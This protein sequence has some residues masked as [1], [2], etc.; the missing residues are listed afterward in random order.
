MSNNNR[1]GSGSNGGKSQ[2][3]L[4]V[5]LTQINL[6][7]SVDAM[8]ALCGLCDRVMLQ[9]PNRGSLSASHSFI[10]LIQEPYHINNKIKGL[11]GK[12]QLFVDI[13]QK[14]PPRA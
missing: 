14:H 3:C 2:S 1:H 7:H 10:A 12:N 6:H 9:N 4:R 11:V 13:Q 8:S 5:D